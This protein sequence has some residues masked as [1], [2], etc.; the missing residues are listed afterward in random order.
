MERKQ[1][2]ST[3]WPLSVSIIASLAVSAVIGLANVVHVLGLTGG[4]IGGRLL[5]VLPI[6]FLA[7]FLSAQFAFWLLRWLVGRVAALFRDASDNAGLGARGHGVVVLLTFVVAALLQYAES[8]G[9]QRVLQDRADSPAAQEGSCPPGLACTS[10]RPAG[11]LKAAD[12]A[13]R[14]AAAERSLLTAE[15]FALLLRDPDPAVRATLARRADL[16]QE[17]LERLAGD[18][19][20]SVREAV[21]GELRLGDGALSR[22]ALDRVESV[23]LAVARNRNAPPTA[24]EFLAGSSSAEI[25]LLVAEHPRASEPVLLRL[26]NDSTD[27]AEQVAR[28]RLPGGKAR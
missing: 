17:L 19:H 23:R 22:L 14:R 24:L 13:T 18:R 21:A 27:R 20:P 28:E 4:S 11:E 26:L 15:G 3:P 2:P 8:S 9:V 10:L 6:Y 5:A 1:S 16:P 12:A 25:R 7:A